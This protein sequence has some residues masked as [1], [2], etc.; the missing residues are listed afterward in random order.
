MKPCETKNTIALIIKKV[1]EY[2][3]QLYGNDGPTSSPHSYCTNRNQ[4]WPGPKPDRVDAQTDLMHIYIWICKGTNS[5]LARALI[6]FQKSFKIKTT[7]VNARL[8]P[9]SNLHS[10]STILK[11]KM[12]SDKKLDEIPILQIAPRESIREAWVNMPAIDHQESYLGKEKTYY[13]TYVCF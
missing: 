13:N 12:C 7:H 6:Q 3:R 4:A 1:A 11:N 5:D 8:E 10:G 9:S 2:K